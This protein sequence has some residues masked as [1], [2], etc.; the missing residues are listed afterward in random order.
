MKMKKKVTNF[1]LNKLQRIHPLFRTNEE[2][3][4][5][6]NSRLRKFRKKGKK[7]IIA[8]QI[9]AIWYLLIL[10]VSYLTT[11]TGAAFNDIE[12]IENSLHVQW[13]KQPEQPDNNEW[14]KSSLDFDGSKAWVE[15][16]KVY[17]TIK[18]AGDRANSTSTW[19]FYL[20][21]MINN[22]PSGEP[23]AEGVVPLIQSGEEGIISATVTEN[24]EFQFAIRR[25]QGHPAK[26]NKEFGMEGYTY[27]GWS[28]KI[29]IT[30]ISNSKEPGN[31]TPPPKEDETQPPS[32]N[33]LPLGE[34]RELSWV[35]GSGNSGKVKVSWKNPENT[36]LLDHVRVYVEGEST[37]IEGKENIKN[38]V[39][40]SKEE[41]STP[42]TYRIVTV[43]KSGEESAGIKITVSKDEVIDHSR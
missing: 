3:S 36:E 12:V 19:R 37:P 33:V 5:I 11:N 7:L 24:G 34:V 20:Y 41:T 1:V 39:E 43:D 29:T 17:S 10:S 30:N 15:G 38:Q 4:T 13:D 25:P 23:V 31:S 28:Q 9:V 22:K 6:R 32:D 35:F 16:N 27:I 2:G 26:N 14:D 42:T 40:F 8:A 18:N 21:K